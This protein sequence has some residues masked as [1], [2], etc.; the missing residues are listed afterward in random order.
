MDN[1]IPA[2]ICDVDNTIVNI[3]HRYYLLNGPATDWSKFL[4]PELIKKDTPMQD[5][6][7]VINALNE[8][9]PILFATGRNSGIEEITRWQIETFCSLKGK[10]YKLFMRDDADRCRP[11]TVVK[12]ELY[13]NHIEPYYRVVAAFDDRPGVV[14]LWRS[15]GITT[16]HVGE[17]SVGG[18]F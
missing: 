6:I 11:D 4:D 12:T 7:D 14:D 3:S 1:K 8:V 2:I 16:Y 18:G 13:R 5:T 10:G 9:Y 17:L 15:F